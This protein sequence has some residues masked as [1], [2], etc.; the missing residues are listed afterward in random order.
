MICVHAWLTLKQRS[1]TLSCAHP[2]NYSKPQ[3]SFRKSRMLQA[4]PLTCHSPY[5]TKINKNCILISRNLLPLIPGRPSEYYEA[6]VYLW[7]VYN[8]DSYPSLFHPAQYGLRGF[9]VIFSQIAEFNEW[10][11]IRA[12]CGLHPAHLASLISQHTLPSWN[13]LRIIAPSVT[14][15]LSDPC[16]SLGTNLSSSDSNSFFPNPGL[17]VWKSWVGSESHLFSDPNDEAGNQSSPCSLSV[18]PRH[19]AQTYRL[20]WVPGAERGDFIRHTGRGCGHGQTWMWIPAPL[21]SLV[22]NKSHE[23]PC[24]SSLLVSKVGAAVWLWRRSR[25]ATSVKA[26]STAELD[27]SRCLLNHRGPIGFS[28]LIWSCGISLYLFKPLYAFRL[29]CDKWDAGICSAALSSLKRGF[30]THLTLSFCSTRAIPCIE[31][32]LRNRMGE[33]EICSKETLVRIS[34]WRLG[35]S[36]SWSQLCPY[37]LAQWQV[38]VFNRYLLNTWIWGP[39]KFTSQSP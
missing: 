11:L 29:G 30:I 31:I 26:L 21:S 5:E 18:G 22:S 9:R 20:W 38:I 34:L 24:A 15:N 1:R 7:W 27:L 28:S 6:L 14:F 10:D 13:P 37:H 32:V 25:R 3:M 17:Q 23:P 16:S 33:R 35:S 4:F 39:G 36:L 8:S 2:S 19:G 12:A